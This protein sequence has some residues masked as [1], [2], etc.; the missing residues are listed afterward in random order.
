[1]T[2]NHAD[3]PRR[4]AEHP[5]FA[6]ADPIAVGGPPPA[7]VA[8]LPAAFTEAEC[9]RLRD[10]VDLAPAE[11]AAIKAART[12]TA[13]RESRIVWLP[14]DPAWR[15]VEERMARLLAEANR[16]LFGFD[17]DGFDER[18][19]IAR[20]GAAEGGH[21]DW[22]VDRA[23][24][25]LARRRKVSISVQLSN[26]PEYD[27]GALEVFAD[28]RLWR[29]PHAQ[30]TAVLFASLLGHRVTPVT[31]GVRHSLVAWAHGPALR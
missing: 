25:G 2:T 10:L 16:A 3:P 15:W 8:V 30:G 5:A 20:Y 18:F 4:P 14:E 1:M 22:H 13:I 7:Y 28:G 31:R 9:L 11:R 26:A 12:P 21:F 19:Q 24:S 23:A 17:L 6:D 27:G 29:A